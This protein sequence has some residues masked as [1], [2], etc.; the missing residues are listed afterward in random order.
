MST[1][2]I[3]FYGELDKIIPYYHLILLNNSSETVTAL[4]AQLDVC[5]TGDQEVAGWTPAR[6]ATFFHGDLIMKYFL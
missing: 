1:H 5:P 6:S 4:V 3:C 2:N